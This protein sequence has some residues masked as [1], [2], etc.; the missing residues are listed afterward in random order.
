M[1]YLHASLHH[2]VPWEDPTQNQLIVT[3]VYS[4]LLT[5]FLTNNE[6]LGTLANKQSSPLVEILVSLT[7]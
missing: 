6:N 5:H 2:L 4:L 7:V 3:H 1:I